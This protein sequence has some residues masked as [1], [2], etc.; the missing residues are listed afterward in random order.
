MHSYLMSLLLKKLFVFKCNLSMLRLT[1]TLTLLGLPLALTS[2][3]CYHKRIRPPIEWLSP[4][5]EAVLLAFF[6]VSWFF[7]FLYYTE[8]PSLL[9]VVLTVVAAS[10][11]NHW[12]A[13]LVCHAFR[14]RFC[15]CST[16]LSLA[17]LV[18]HFGKQM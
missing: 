4:S 1:T 16:E 15:H 10:N 5:P 9:T 12:Q 8:I 3:L 6:P 14:Q 17:S 18:A 13:A 7:G 11:H 2:L